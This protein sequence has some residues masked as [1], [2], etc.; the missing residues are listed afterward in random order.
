MDTIVHRL[1]QQALAPSTLRSYEIAQRR[2]LTFCT[3]INISPFPV[4]ETSLCRYVA[5]LANDK[6]RFQTIKCYLSA[7]RYL[8]IMSGFGDP[9]MASMPILEYLLKG[10]KRDQAKQNPESTR[11]RLPIT[12]AILRSLRSEL[13]KESTKWNNIMLWAACCTCFFGFLRSGE[14]TVPSQGDYDSSAHLSYGDVTFDSEH[15]PTMAQINIK[16]SK[17]DP[18]RKGVTICVGR[19]DND[20]C[21]VAAL[22]A[23]TTIRGTNDGPFFVLENRAPLTRE[24]FV[25]MIKGKLSAAGINP[26]C[27]SGHSFRIGAATTAA[28]CGVEDSL[29]QTLGRWKSAAYLLYVRVPRERLAN[30]STVLAK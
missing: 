22:A 16:A 28:A 10:V 25:K 17:T 12:P 24:Q 1:L 9:Y 5:N 30:L 4:N 6:L 20:L 15:S 27:Y 26:S 19:T 23:Y 29:I 2:Y 18:F 8:Q 7:I 11:S 3:K 14:I 13:D 21:P